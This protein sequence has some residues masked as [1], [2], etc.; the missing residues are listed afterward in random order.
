MI[1]K[2]NTG[3]EYEKYI[4]KII[5][6]KYKFCWLW[7]DVPKNILKTYNFINCEKE[8]CDDIGCDIVAQTFDDKFEFIQ[9]KNYSTTSIDNTIFIVDL[10]GFYNFIAENTLVG[11]VYYSGK[12]SSQVLSRARKIKYI[13]VPNIIH[14][15]KINIIPRDYQIEAYNKL[16]DQ[17]LSILNMPCGTGKTFVTY[18]MSLDYKNTI[19][20]TPLISTTEQITTH[21]KNYYNNEKVNF[22]EINSKACRDLKNIKLLDK[23]IISSTYDSYDIINKMNFDTNETL[24]IIDEFHNLTSN[25]LSKSNNEYI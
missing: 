12:L 7:N 16:K 5:E 13:N 1:N 9:C 25:N 3:Q 17:Q 8:T 19:I 20:L 11:I 15:E 14:T 4:L 22:I 6:S 10:A 18:L 2:L 23:N 21:Y 24:L